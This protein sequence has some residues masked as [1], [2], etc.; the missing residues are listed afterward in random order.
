M[1]S[2]CPN[3]L[4]RGSRD[5]LCHACQ[6]RVRR[7]LSRMARGLMPRDRDLNVP[8]AMMRRDHDPRL[9]YLMVAGWGNH[10]G[11]SRFEAE[12]RLALGG[13]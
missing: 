1:C 12:R 11:V 7:S 9:T 13:V 10:A 5:L 4:P 2:F 6:C 3:Q 8:G